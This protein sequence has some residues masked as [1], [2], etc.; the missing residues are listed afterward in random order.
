MKEA[1]LYRTDSLFLRE[2][3][4]ELEKQ[5]IPYRLTDERSAADG[6]VLFVIL[7][8]LLAEELSP[9]Y[10][11][12]P[13]PGGIFF[14]HHLLD[15]L[16]AGPLYHQADAGGCMA[17]L[18]QKYKD[19]G[20]EGLLPLLYGEKT[21]YVPQPQAAGFAADCIRGAL[22]A[23]DHLH[24]YIGHVE[25]IHWDALRVEGFCCAGMTAVPYAPARLHL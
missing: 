14:L 18:A 1:V 16:L 22:L 25:H 23:A 7:D 11:E 15:T 5:E 13:G 12:T 17:C 8:Q 2:V 4:L 20:R 19:T 21:E 9:F 6:S 3:V 24:R 10:R